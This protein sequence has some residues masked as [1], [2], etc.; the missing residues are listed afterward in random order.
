[1]RWLSVSGG[2]SVMHANPKLRVTQRMVFEPGHEV[3]AA[4]ERLGISLKRRLR[5]LSLGNED[6]YADL[7]QEAFIKL[8]DLDPTRFTPSE[9]HVL[10]RLVVDHIRAVANRAYNAGRGHDL[11]VAD[12]ER[13][14][15]RRVPR[16]RHTEDEH[17]AERGTFL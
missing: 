14:P 17:D 4:I 8:W 11:E 9:D 5:K 15:V 3:V 1:M 2:G 12:R 6:L 10:L 13:L 16:R 7:N